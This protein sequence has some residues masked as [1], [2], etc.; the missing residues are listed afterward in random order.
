[1]KKY[2]PNLKNLPLILAN[3]VIKLH[4]MLNVDK[5]IHSRFKNNEFPILEDWSNDMTFTY[6]EYKNRLNIIYKARDQ[7]KKL[8]KRKTYAQRTEEWY[9]IRLNMLTASDTYAGI[10][11]YKSLI[12]SKALKSNK[13]ITCNAMYWGIAFETISSKIYSLL[14]NNITIHEFGLI[15]STEIDFYGAS[16]DGISDLGIM[17]EIKCPISREIKNNYIPDKYYAQMQGQLAVCE[18]Q[19]CDY[20]EFVF[21]EINKD[22]FLLLKKKND[23]GKSIY[24][25]MIVEKIDGS[26][27][28][29]VLKQDV[30]LIYINNLD[31]NAKRT[32][33]WKLKKYN[34]QRVNFDKDLWYNTYIPKI[35]EFWQNVINFK[36]PQLTYLDDSD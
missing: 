29:S 13:H 10:K 22:D 30:N 18:L 25:G 20:A 15:P 23:K 36:E 19:E 14:N 26:L 21:E 32:I 4:N 3:F 16:P 9:N 1:L 17:L 11:Q 34:I 31:L 35:K 27:N 28:Y 2:Q 12:R 5:Y 33:Y 6:D 24:Y 7:L 8:K